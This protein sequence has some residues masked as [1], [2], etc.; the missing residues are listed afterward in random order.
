MAASRR[1]QRSNRPTAP[2]PGCSLSTPAAMTTPSPRSS[3]RSSSGSPIG[4]A[5]NS[6]P[7]RGSRPTSFRRSRPARG[8]RWPPSPPPRGGSPMPRGPERSSPGRAPKSLPPSSRRSPSSDRIRWRRSKPSRSWRGSAARPFP[9]AWRQGG[10]TS[11]RSPSSKPSRRAGRR[12]RRPRSGSRP[13]TS[14]WHAATAS[15]ASRGLVA[16]SSSARETSISATTPSSTPRQ[17]WPAGRS[18]TRRPPESSSFPMR[19]HSP[20]PPGCRGMPP[21]G[22]ASSGIFPRCSGPS[23]LSS[24]T[25]SASRGCLTT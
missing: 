5:K 19:L 2:L 16:S 20:R 6:L 25:S 9:P 22:S 4:G 10:G 13:T 17:P 21:A 1:W 18:A 3:K 7:L 11:I 8:D 15:T 14:R 23:S 24:T 12:R